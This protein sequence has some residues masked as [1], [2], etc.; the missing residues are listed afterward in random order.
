MVVLNKQFDMFDQL[1]ND[2]WYMVDMTEYQFKIF[3]IVT[4]CRDTLGPM[5]T[6]YDAD[7]RNCRWHGGQVDTHVAGVLM[8]FAFKDEADYTM[9]RLKFS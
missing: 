7:I 9:L 4:W 2:D 8:L 3:D 6:I 5:L 1:K